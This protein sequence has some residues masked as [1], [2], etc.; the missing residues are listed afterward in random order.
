MFSARRFL[1]LAVKELQQ[2]RKNKRLMVQLVVPPTLALVL[3]GL[4]LNPEVKGLR[5][6]VADGSRTRESRQ[7]VDALTAN[8]AFRIAAWY[9]SAGEAEEALRRLELD[10]VVVIPGDYARLLARRRPAQVQVWIDSVNTNTATIAQSYLTQSAS[11]L[12]R[13]LAVEVRPRIES[14]PAI[15][16]NPGS[17][18][19]WFYVTGVMS[20][21]MFLNSAL[22]A[23]ALAVREKELGTIEQLLMSPAQTLEVLVAKTVPVW[24]LALLVLLAALEVGSLVFGLPQRGA[25]WL[26]LL[27]ASLAAVCGI[28][29]GITL[30]TFSQTQQQAQLLTFF[31]MP[32]LVLISGVFTPIE[33]MP[34]VFQYLSLVD[35][36]R[37]LARLLRGVVLR[38]AGID[39]LWPQ[40][41]VL[42]GFSVALYGL[43]AWRFRGQL[44]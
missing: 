13:R 35:P 31:L 3:F 34:V 44:R 4:A 38:G 29:I 17:T 24:A 7:L 40:L 6:G 25:W 15:L 12:A 22:V 1:A 8:E 5:M 30:A 14:A 28:G 18:H 9:G 20:V 11:A 10:L 23:S 39:V 42:A 37:Y 21:L 43:S 33:S 2:L 36:I 19:A 41:A 16:Y 26:L 32:P 27:S